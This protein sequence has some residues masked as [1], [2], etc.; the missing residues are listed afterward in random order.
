MGLSLEAGWDN[1]AVLDT[2]YNTLAV[3]IFGVFGRW[4]DYTT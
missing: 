2:I 4:F 1:K 3:M